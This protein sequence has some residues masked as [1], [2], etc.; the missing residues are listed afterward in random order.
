VRR[1]AD[2]A[3]PSTGPQSKADDSLADPDAL[4]PVSTRRA[5]AIRASGRRLRP[6][7]QRPRGARGAARHPPHARHRAPEQE[8]GDRGAGGP[9]ASATREPGPV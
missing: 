5:A 6:A 7:R 1:A 8:A 2:P 3:E 9:Q 4:T